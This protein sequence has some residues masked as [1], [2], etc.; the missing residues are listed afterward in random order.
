MIGREILD[1]RGNPTVESKCLAGGWKFRQGNRTDRI[2][3][4]NRLLRVERARNRRHSL[5]EVRLFTAWP[6]LLPALY[7]GISGGVRLPSRSLRPITPIAGSLWECV[8]NVLP[9]RFP[10]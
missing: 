10:N 6:G 5:L 2:A 1:S 7:P 9:E 4:R 8:S 3:M